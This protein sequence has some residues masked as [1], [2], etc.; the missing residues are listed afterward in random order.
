MSPSSSF[1]VNPLPIVEGEE[2]MTTWLILTV[3]WFEGVVI[4]LPIKLSL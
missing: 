1:C 3:L 4:R 2:V